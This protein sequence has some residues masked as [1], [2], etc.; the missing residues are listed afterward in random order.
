MADCIADLVAPGLYLGNIQALAALVSCEPEEQSSWCVVSVLDDRDRYGLQ[1]PR[2]VHGHH[3][4]TIRDAP[5]D[6][7]SRHFA[8]AHEFIRKSLEQDKTVL[9]HCMAGISRS[10]SIV[11][12]HLM[13]ER[14]IRRDEA[15]AIVKRARPIAGPNHGFRKQLK[16]LEDV[17]FA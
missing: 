1:V 13:L 5:G 4:I 16:E 15:L 2:H 9:V 6:D 12:A 11:A 17:I 3:H 7:L 8:H 10:A 14:K